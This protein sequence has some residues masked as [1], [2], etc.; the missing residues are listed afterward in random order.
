MGV[1]ACERNNCP[2]IMCD[3]LSPEF[4]YL[5]DDCFNE[6][7]K[8]GPAT[9]VA[10]FMQTPKTLGSKKLEEASLAYFERIFQNR[11]DNS[12]YAL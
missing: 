10:E 9:N 4:G 11:H 3:R 8:L 12:R 7:V 1:L 5:C 6:L 2:N